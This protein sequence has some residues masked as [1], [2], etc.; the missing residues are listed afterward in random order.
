LLIHSA[1]N[2]L[3]AHGEI[4]AKSHLY[5][6][7]PWG[8][9]QQP[10]FLNQAIHFA[11]DLEPIALLHACKSMETALGRQ[12]GEQWHARHIDIDMVL[13]GPV[14]L[15]HPEL[16]LPHP[17]LHERNFVLVPLMEIAP[18]AVHPVFG[19][20]IEE[21]FLECRDQGEVYIFNADEQ[22]GPL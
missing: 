9:E 3:A 6:T 7:Q 2:L 16:T 14:I 4:M 10:W 18:Y 22:H 13:A 8:Y 15:D 11:A 17:R 12:P 20:T 1:R 5:E 19:K 21:L